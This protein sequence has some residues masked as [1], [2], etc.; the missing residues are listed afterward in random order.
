M[1]AVLSFIV[2]S[3]LITATSAQAQSLRGYGLKA[4][5]TSASVSTNMFA[6]GIERREGIAAM[7]F[8]EGLTRGR[9]TLVGE[10]GYAQRGYSD[11]VEQRGPEGEAIG[12]E[13]DGTRFDYLSAAALAK[14]RYPGGTLEPYAVAGPRVDVLLGGNPSA[15]L[16]ESYD[17]VAAGGTLGLGVEAGQTFVPVPVFLEAR[18]HFDVTNSLSC[19]PR[20]MRNRAF[21]VLLGIRL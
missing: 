15:A 1:R 9:F 21:D 3:L 2:L 18:Y 5:L 20:D 4:G 10:L 19:C 8:A 12:I 13:D 11:P 16:I 6:E 14:L 7:V 17:R